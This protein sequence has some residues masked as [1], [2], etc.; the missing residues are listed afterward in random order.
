MSATPKYK[1]TV[2]YHNGNR[3][4]ER[5]HDKAKAFAYRNRMAR[6][7]AVKEAMF[8]EVR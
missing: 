4:V 5:F 8:Q 6:N 3:H 2:V 7:P 1:V